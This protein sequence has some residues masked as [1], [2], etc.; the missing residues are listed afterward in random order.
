M[1]GRGGAAAI[2]HCPNDQIGTTDEVSAGK[3]ASDAG[4][5]ILVNYDAS[6]FV[7]RDLIGIAG[8]K[9]GDGIETVGDEHDDRSQLKIRS[10]E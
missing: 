5:L 6:P 7:D 9:N 10:R 3:Y 1:N 8:G 2:A 4:H